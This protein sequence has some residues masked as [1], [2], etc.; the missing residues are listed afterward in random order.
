MKAV[1]G[2]ACGEQGDDPLDLPPAAEMLD[3]ADLAAAVGAR[4]GLAGGIVA[5][6][7]D[8]IGRIGGRRAVWKVDV[9]LQRFFPLSLLCPLYQRRLA[10]RRSAM[11]NGR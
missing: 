4:G 8:K 1:A 3:I 2:G 5:E 11:L 10:K 6:A 9:G 7:R